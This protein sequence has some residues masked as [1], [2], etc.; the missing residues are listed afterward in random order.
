M[1][2]TDTN[3]QNRPGTARRNRRGTRSDDGPLEAPSS[4]ALRTPPLAPQ[5]DVVIPVYNEEHGLRE[6]VE[7]LDAYLAGLYP[8]DGPGYRITIA[9]NASTDATGAIAAEL[10][11]AVEAVSYLRLEEKGRGR[12]LRAAWSASDAAILAYMDV[13]LSTGLDAFPALVAPLLSGHSDVAIGSRLAAGARVQRGSKRE[14]ISRCYNLLLHGS[15]GTGFSDAQCGFKALSASAAR[16]L[17]P[18]V[19]DEAWFFDTELL[20][21]AEQAGLRISEVAVDWVDDPDSSVH[22]A[23]TAWEDLKGVARLSAGLLSGR[24]PLARLRRELGRDPEP[25]PERGLGSHLLRFAAVGVGSTLAYLLLF[26]L[27]RGGRWGRSSPT[28]SRS[29][30]PRWP[31]RRPTA[32]SPSG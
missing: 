4:L 30:P 32:P 18:L 31:T 8:G 14:V 10:A 27:L 13:D 20:V 19:R 21:L 12:A 15:L 23:G 11:R 2:P 29:W 1:I 9:D 6:A 24:I 26:V 16:L 25:A 5:V 7:R 17:L 22:L 3:T 28:S